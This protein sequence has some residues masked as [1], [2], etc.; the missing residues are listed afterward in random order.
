[1]VWMVALQA[2]GFTSMPRVRMSGREKMVEVWAWRNER[3]TPEPVP[4]SRM[5]GEGEFL[6]VGFVVV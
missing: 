5:S 2:C 1:M 4:I 6:D 3:T